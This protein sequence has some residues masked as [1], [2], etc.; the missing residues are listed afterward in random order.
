MVTKYV[1]FKDVL[2]LSLFVFSSAEISKLVSF[3]NSINTMSKFPSRFNPTE[4]NDNETT[5]T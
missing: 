4:L 1:Q 5:A 2:L 3:D